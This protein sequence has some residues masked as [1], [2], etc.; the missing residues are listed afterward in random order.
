MATWKKV[1]TESDN[2]TH[3]NESITLAQL[4]AGL[5]A[6]STAAA[7]Q[8]LKVNANHTALE[9][10][11]DDDVTSIGGLSNVTDSL[12][13]SNGGALIVG[14]NSGAYVSIVPTGDVA[15]SNAG[16][17]TIGTDKIK[18]GM[19][20]NDQIDSQHYADGSI[21]TAHIADD[22]VTYAKM[23]DIGTANRVLGKTSTGTIEEVQIE[24]AMIANDA[25]DGT[26]LANNIDIAGTLDVTSTA[27]FDGD[28]AILGKL[29]MTGDIDT[30]SVTDLD[31]ADKTI[32]LSSSTSTYVDQNA[33]LTA[34]NGAGIRLQNQYNSGNAST[35][36][37]NMSASITWDNANNLSGWAVKD[38]TN[39]PSVAV[40]VMDF[41]GSSGQDLSGVNAS[42]VGSFS[43]N[44]ADDELYV[45]VG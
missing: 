23:Q 2:S 1:I 25:V 8:I 30:V 33:M 34:T 4:F 15:M 19:I 14:N 11:A 29:T 26:K 13:A 9:W 40:A 41:Q 43:F 28:V 27:T 21:D 5:D 44:T 31:V 35:T 39:V 7:N 6:S 32:T 36:L 24:T 20:S 17:L 38:F 10:A 3:K 12:G 22:Q 18:T 37:A 45:R 42:G 16:A